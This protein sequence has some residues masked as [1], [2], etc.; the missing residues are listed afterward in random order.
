MVRDCRTAAPARGLPM[1]RF[2]VGPQQVC[3]DLIYMT[4]RED[5]KHLS[6]VL[7]LG[8]GDSL[9]ISDAQAFEYR[10]E[11][12]AVEKERVLLRICERQSFARE[13]QLLLR[14]YQGIPKQAK[15][16]TIVQKCV[17]LGVHCIVPVFTKYTV[18]TD[19]R[20]N[21][22]AKVRRWQKI[23][24]EAAKQCRRGRI[25][26]VKEAI[27][28]KEMAAQAKEDCDVVLF[29]YEGERQTSIK[30]ALLRRR[31]EAQRQGRGIRS[32]AVIVGPEGGFSEEEAQVM[33]SAGA[34]CVTLGKTILRTETAGMAAAAMIM[35]EL[36]LV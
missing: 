31:E 3:G 18:V 23:S 33:I 15:M 34:D 12:Q 21:F 22:S 6:R 19:S 28:F 4:D 35:Y 13:P 26:A 1:S 8:A 14:L 30:Q 27:S 32:V 17:E 5:I 11:I 29:L 2:F 9:D 36:E 20:G 16:E 25:P 24:E 7:R 10:C